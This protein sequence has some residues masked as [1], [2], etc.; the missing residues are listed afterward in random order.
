MKMEQDLKAVE[1]SLKDY[2]KSDNLYKC[3]S[4]VNSLSFVNVESKCVR[5]W[6]DYLPI[7]RGVGLEW[8]E[9]MIGSTMSA[10][11]LYI[12]NS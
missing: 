11:R 7:C 6:A 2:Q 1:F 4:A 8:V 9:W 10:F 3:S 5:R 12:F